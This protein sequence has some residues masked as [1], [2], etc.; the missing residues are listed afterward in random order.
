MRNTGGSDSIHL[1]GIGETGG[2]L[3]IVP[4]TAQAGR[5]FALHPGLGPLKELFDGGRAAVV[6]NV[7]T[8]IAADH[9][10]PV[11]GE[12]RGAAAQAVLAQ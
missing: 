11:Q 7:G 4:A 2:V 12:K 5:S 3:P 8:L 6:A 9:P 10:G 1:P